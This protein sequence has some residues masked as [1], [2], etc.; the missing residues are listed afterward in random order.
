MPT[1][2]KLFL[3]IAVIVIGAACSWLEAVHRDEAV[4]MVIGGLTAF[5]ILALWLFPE[6][7]VKDDDGRPE[8]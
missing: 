5:M 1:K 3:S 6:A 4:A 8:T 7:G 2:V